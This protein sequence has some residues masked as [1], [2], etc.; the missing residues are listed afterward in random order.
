MSCPASAVSTDKASELACCSVGITAIMD[1]IAATL[2][3]NSFLT[4]CVYSIVRMICHPR[5]D[6]EIDFFE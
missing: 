6:F 3:A 4:I 2:R 1:V 5:T